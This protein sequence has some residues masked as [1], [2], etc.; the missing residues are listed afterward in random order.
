VIKR[1]M[2][3]RIDCGKDYPRSIGDKAGGL[4]TINGVLYELDFDQIPDGD[5]YCGQGDYHLEYFWK[6]KHDEMPSLSGND[7][8]R[9]YGISYG[10]FNDK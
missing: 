10:M 8:T 1:E 6:R 9:S 2:P 7:R 4:A 5:V 3:D